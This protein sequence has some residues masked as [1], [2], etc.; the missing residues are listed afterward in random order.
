MR[1][2]TERHSLAVLS[3]R[4]FESVPAWNRPPAGYGPHLHRCECACGWSGG[5]HG[6]R[7]EALSEHRC[8]VADVSPASGWPDQHP[9][10]ELPDLHDPTLGCWDCGG[11]HQRGDGACPLFLLGG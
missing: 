6:R 5:W 7:R 9:E 11:P 10:A 1:T 4:A 2:T 3:T 8:H